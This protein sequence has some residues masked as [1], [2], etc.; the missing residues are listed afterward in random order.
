MAPQPG[1]SLQAVL[2]LEYFTVAFS[3][4]VA[5]ASI[6]FGT[7][8]L[9][10]ALVG[11][12]LACLIESL[13]GLVLIWRLGNHENTPKDKF[14]GTERRVQQVVSAVFFLFGI[15]VLYES[16]NRIVIQEAAQP[17]PAGI[18]IS[19]LLLII[20]PILAWKKR[21]VGTVMGSRIVL[22]NVKETIAFAVLSGA[23]LAGLLLN[24]LYGVWQAD[25][26]AGLVIAIFL[27]HEGYQ[28]WCGSCGG[29][30]CSGEE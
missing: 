12:G 10:M 22:A 23:F 5:V 13:S 29:C 19:L 14:A 28:T 2:S 9:S 25:S 6:F 16:V 21:V 18:I 1:R 17:S 20:M 15:Y 30:E 3:F 8:A 24:Y 27:F 7:A 11:F 4:V 26:F